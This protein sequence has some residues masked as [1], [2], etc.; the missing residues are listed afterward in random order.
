MYEDRKKERKKNAKKDWIIDTW[1]K[2]FDE[3]EQTP[4]PPIPPVDQRIVVPGI[5]APRTQANVNPQGWE[6]RIKEAQARLDA[7]KAALGDKNDTRSTLQ[8]ALALK[9]MEREVRNAKK[10]SPGVPT[11]EVID[12]AKDS[13]NTIAPDGQVFKKGQNYSTG[14]I[15]KNEE[16]GNLEYK[17]FAAVPTSQVLK[18]LAIPWGG[19]IPPIPEDPNQGATP[20]EK[21]PWYKAFGEGLMDPVN[22]LVIGGM[23]LFNPDPNTAFVPSRSTLRPELQNEYPYMG[24]SI[25]GNLALA[26]PGANIAGT[27]ARG[28]G[29]GAGT[30]NVAAGALTGAAMTA[31][32]AYNQAASKAMTPGEAITSTVLG[33]VGGGTASA[34]GGA[35]AKK[36]VG[37]TTNL[38]GQAA[39]DFGVGFGT[40]FVQ[41]AVNNNELPT[42]KTAAIQGG[43]NALTGVGIGTATVFGT[44]LS[45]LLNGQKRSN[46]KAAANNAAA[47]EVNAQ[48]AAAS[49][50]EAKTQTQ[51]TAYGQTAATFAKGAGGGDLNAV[52]GVAP[53]ASPA[54]A[55]NTLV[56]FVQSA[57]NGT[58]PNRPTEVVKTIK[59]VMQNG[60][61]P[62]SKMYQDIVAGNIEGYNL[63][64]VSK[65]QEKYNSD[66]ATKVKV[67]TTAQLPRIISD[68]YTTLQQA[69]IQDLNPNQ[70]IAVAQILTG[71][72]ISNAEVAQ[73]KILEY[74]VGNKS[75]QSIADGVAAAAGRAQLQ[76]ELKTQQAQQ[77]LEQKA[78]TAASKQKE[79]EG[80][81]AE[82][83]TKALLSN[84]GVPMP[85]GADQNLIWQNVAA[86]YNKDG[87]FADL[88]A[89]VGFAGKTLN[90]AQS[91]VGE[92]GDAEM[93]DLLLRGVGK[94]GRLPE[95]ELR[96]KIAEDMLRTGATADEAVD[97]IRTQKTPAEQKEAADTQKAAQT[98]GKTT[99]P[100]T[101]G[102]IGGGNPGMIYEGGT[103]PP[104]SGDY[105][106]GLEAAPVDAPVTVPEAPQVTPHTQALVKSGDGYTVGAPLTGRS[107]GSLS[108]LQKTIAATGGQEAVDAIINDSNLQSGLIAVS[109]LQP[110]VLNKL[111]AEMGWDFTGMNDSQKRAFVLN[112]G[113]KTAE[114]ILDVGEVVK[115]FGSKAKDV[116]QESI[117]RSIISGK[118]IDLDATFG[119]RKNKPWEKFG[120]DSSTGT[121]SQGGKLWT[122]NSI[123]IKSAIE[124]NVAPTLKEGAVAGALAGTGGL[125]G[126]AA[127][128][129]KDL[130]K[131]TG[132]KSLTIT[133]LDLAAAYNEAK[134]K[135]LIDDTPKHGATSTAKAPL[136][137]QGVHKGLDF[138]GIKD[139]SKP[140]EEGWTPEL[141]ADIDA[142]FD[143]RFGKIDDPTNRKAVNE[144]IVNLHNDIEK[145]FGGLGPD[146]VYNRTGALLKQFEQKKNSSQQTDTP[147]GQSSE[148]TPEI[149]KV[150]AISPS[151]YFKASPGAKSVVFKDTSQGS[152]V[153]MDAVK[154]DMPLAYEFLSK[155]RD[156][157]KFTPID[158]KNALASAYKRR[159]RYKVDAENLIAQIRELE[160]L[161]SQAD[162]GAKTSKDDFK[163]QMADSRDFTPEQLEL[164]SAMIDGLNTSH[165]PDYVA[166]ASGDNYYSF[167]TN[168]LVSKEPDVFLHEIGHFSFYN[169]LSPEDRIAYM[170][171]MVD[172]SYGKNGKSLY[173]KNGKSLGERLALTSE[174][175]TENI[176]GKET[177]LIANVGDNFSE[178]FAEQFRQWY[179]GEKVTPKEFDNIFAKVADYMRRVLEKL[180][181]GE[182]IDKNLVL[183]FEKISP[184]KPKRT[185]SRPGV[186]NSVVNSQSPDITTVE[187]KNAPRGN[188]E[189]PKNTQEYIRKLENAKSAWL[190]DNETKLADAKEKMDDAWMVSG[191]R[192]KY[193]E[194]REGYYKLKNELGDLNPTD[195]AALT[196]KL[197][198]IANNKKFPSGRRLGAEVGL[199]LIDTNPAL[200]K[201]ISLHIAA[202]ADGITGNWNPLDKEIKISRNST[203]KLSIPHE[204]LHSV[205]RFLPLDLRARIYDEWWEHLNWYI[206]SSNPPK[207]E[208][209][210][211]EKLR[212]SYING[213]GYREASDIFDAT[214]G[215]VPYEL[216]SPKEWFTVNGTDLIFTKKKGEDGAPK[217]MSAAL[218]AKIVEFFNG[219]ADAI[220]TTIQKWTNSTVRPE[221]TIPL[222][223]IKTY[224]AVLEA[225][226]FITNPKN[227]P[228]EDGDGIPQSYHERN[229][230]L[231][232][233]EGGG[234]EA[235]AK[236]IDGFYSPLEAKIETAPTQLSAN[237]WLERLGKGDE[238]RFTGLLDYLKSF[239]PNEQIKSDA[240]LKFV[241]ENRVKVELP[242]V[243]NLE[244]IGELK[245]EKSALEEQI[246]R[247]TDKYGSMGLTLSKSRRRYMADKFEILRGA[248]NLKLSLP[249]DPSRLLSWYDVFDRFKAAAELTGTDV[250]LENAKIYIEYKDE[251]RPLNQRLS[252][253]NLEIEELT[254]QPNTEYGPESH[255]DQYTTPGESSDYEVSVIRLPGA[256]DLK[257][258]FGDDNIGHVRSDVRDN[259]DGTKDLHVEEIQSDAGQRFIRKIQYAK[260]MGAT[261]PVHGH[262]FIGSTTAWTNLLA[263]YAL[264]RAAALDTQTLSWPIGDEQV[265]RYSEKQRNGMES[266]YGTP[267]SW[268]M[269]GDVIKSLTG[270]TPKLSEIKHGEISWDAKIKTLTDALEQAHGK[271]PDD[272]PAVV[273]ARN[274]LERITKLRDSGAEQTG[275]L[276][277]KINI[278][279]EVKKMVLEGLPLFDR[280]GTSP[281]P[282][283]KKDNLSTAINILGAGIGAYSL[284]HALAFGGGDVGSLAL[285]GAGLNS[286]MVKKGLGGLKQKTSD[287][288]KSYN[289]KG[290]SINSAY[291]TWVQNNSYADEAAKKQALS[292]IKEQSALRLEGLPNMAFDLNPFHQIA[293]KNSILG[294]IRDKGFEMEKHFSGMS[295]ILDDINTWIKKTQQ[296]LVSEVVKL[297]SDVYNA[298]AAINNDNSIPKDQKAE[299]KEEAT[300]AL[301]S[302]AFAKNPELQAEYEK[303][304]N[305][306]NEASA[307]QIELQMLNDISAVPSTLDARI[308]D[309]TKV[310]DELQFQADDFSNYAN[311]IGKM[312]RIDKAGAFDKLLVNDMEFRTLYSG[313][314]TVRK[315]NRKTGVVTEEE[316]DDKNKILI[317]K[318]H[319]KEQRKKANALRRKQRATERMANYH[320]E[321][322]K[323]KAQSVADHHINLWRAYQ[324]AQRKKMFFGKGRDLQSAT[325]QLRGADGKRYRIYGN[326]KKSVVEQTASIAG[327]E[328]LVMEVEGFALSPTAT[329]D[330]LS[331]GWM[332]KGAIFKDSDGNV[333]DFN[334]FAAAHD[335][336]TNTLWSAI[337]LVTA[338]IAESKLAKVTAEWLKNNPEQAGDSGEL[339]A[340][341]SKI[342]EAAEGRI[343]AEE[344]RTNLLVMQAQQAT[345]PPKTST[346]MPPGTEDGNL[347]QHI[348]NGL[349]DLQNDAYRTGRAVGTREQL[350][351]DALE[352]WDDKLNSYLRRQQEQL[353]TRAAVPFGRNLL[354]EGMNS[355]TSASQLLLLALRPATFAVNLVK[356]TTMSASEFGLG[357]VMRQL[358]G[359][360]IDGFNAAW[361]HAK[362]TVDTQT[363]N[364]YYVG[365]ADRGGWVKSVLRGSTAWS[366][367]IADKVTARTATADFVANLSDADAKLLAGGDKGMLRKLDNHVLNS[368]AMTQ[369]RY[370]HYDL[371]PVH[372]Q[373]LRFPMGRA[374]LAFTLPRI[375][376]L[377]WVWQNAKN[378]KD[379]KSQAKLLRYGMLTAMTVGGLGLPLVADLMSALNSGTGDREELAT[380]K[381]IA[382]LRKLA[383]ENGV[384]GETFDNIR[385]FGAKGAPGA[386]L[387]T[388]LMSDEETSSLLTM[389]MVENLIKVG[390]NIA[391]NLT[392]EEK[393]AAEKILAIT[394]GSMPQLKAVRR[395]ATEASTG[396][397]TDSKG[398]LIPGSSTDAGR[399]TQIF[400]GLGSHTDR[401]AQKRLKNTDLVTEQGLNKAAEN[402]L[403]DLQGM[404]QIIYA[405]KIINSSKKE[406]NADRRDELFK[407]IT[408]NK[409]ELRNVIRTANE[410]TEQAEEKI[411]EA[412]EKLKSWLKTPVSEV[413]GLPKRVVEQG[414]T[415][416]EAMNRTLAI[417]RNPSYNST[418]GVVKR[419]VGSMEDEKYSETSL[420]GFYRKK[421]IIEAV[422][423]SKLGVKAYFNP[424]TKLESG[425]RLK[426]VPDAEQAFEYGK[427]RVISLLQGQVLPE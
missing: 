57:T 103:P 342:T 232:S 141:E 370:Q 372:Q 206:D 420:Y 73:K 414:G 51:A 12:I 415:V 348:A 346:L 147:A 180:K 271:Y 153:D 183:Y 16:T 390:K 135:G 111:G 119:T 424:T 245:K 84:L 227:T 62:G 252:H 323:R 104:K 400:L 247:L 14:R 250:D 298:N 259:A 389:F 40:P 251:I 176:D 324:A 121:F 320:E 182:Y 80:K 194:A 86:I 67:E 395:T 81:V 39:G 243:A 241:D 140:S 30:A 44:G 98:G 70:A 15:Y 87:R 96:N 41:A 113:I 362:K 171:Y 59:N 340:L 9:E 406:A 336:Y 154:S 255:E 369:G 375:N 353:A 235:F 359:F 378:M 356:G 256:T 122:P 338:G 335:D 175:I 257:G 45:N 355:L 83:N 254:V 4:P 269:V 173:G 260:E 290:D 347:A 100:V 285:L 309:F 328:G 17:K 61:E 387:D 301:L 220:R 367:A 326:N 409:E 97:A 197:S 286:D 410:L 426:N 237:K 303:W 203:D 307:L 228:E 162:A 185:K 64:I 196:Q 145:M 310:A 181:S 239:K 216:I 152:V 233:L 287:W 275:T 144:A 107:Q 22:N 273:E 27:A 24:G 199:Y 249:E 240:L 381:A 125:A 364:R 425:G 281:I 71:G 33:G 373:I 90:D 94:V 131:R 289:L 146:W 138:N 351:T 391:G 399:M 50:E 88:N 164:Y 174:K 123:A 266:Y 52:I 108:Q 55:Y 120:I 302:E 166:G 311:N 376:E 270:E 34:I 331:K 95:I 332:P 56:G 417:S 277:W 327:K 91:R 132:D 230:D 379:R 149:T 209:R 377:S 136:G 23:N 77:S 78:N 170:E 246:Y 47:A 187:G 130:R 384:D 163:K 58:V 418:K 18:G 337:D 28:I 405:G 75:T 178:Y 304:R 186:V 11:Q 188:V 238:M 46:A 155:H 69:G 124:L 386:L 74:A 165:M 43:V 265:R 137:T 397:K 2:P 205:E 361:E 158:V 5:G 215:L 248:R 76:S 21:E 161:A 49:A 268:G 169:I 139:T 224:E 305:M 279:P 306:I 321:L 291:N 211:L 282:P 133:Q 72:K 106:P 93:S 101:S 427:N 150:D 421:A 330:Q 126:E 402:F 352:G 115:G 393:T 354:T 319:Q 382:D 274:E 258:H 403:D 68:A 8:K 177:T 114:G 109:E 116:E 92:M 223:E 110:A 366:Q 357:D 341:R 416:E 394:E 214:G 385:K 283:P 54:E 117:N 105:T 229:D 294:G 263:K 284:Y 207:Y 202:I 148:P 411:K 157:N 315:K 79:K 396:T 192:V 293:A 198:D 264:M 312:L 371:S 204:L 413:K 383:I 212:D 300:S 339:K 316:L 242:S 213:G 65:T 195:L 134:K 6:N 20:G 217:G 325:L 350:M 388:E 66:L 156:A 31:P 151:K 363:A 412:G 404:S 322:E 19:A 317:V 423:N 184:P 360:K 29:L 168:E 221:G 10:D 234:V 218:R 253:I 167:A 189:V 63:D 191:D 3:E 172:T 392:D 244:R 261:H 365:E 349:H 422:N 201:D 53:G 401:Q 276:V 297:N 142:K 13:E 1:G 99:Q 296:D 193:M 333:W 85:K 408:K 295:T 236:V 231:A 7:A 143:L 200:Y 112:E 314:K 225:L 292:D 374:A 48:K 398:D 26:V 344:L 329:V 278:T 127:K 129:T 42:I 160:V 334:Q 179:V 313:K 380:D 226:E 219:L 128:A 343:D 208:L 82:Q 102:M 25:A 262:P 60:A 280:A 272:H 118:P 37:L 267:V 36:G 407:H 32:G 288:I 38:A 318:K 308:D 222:K 159:M 35:L 358:P 299:A 419:M 210:T 190:A 345:E 368:I 89:F